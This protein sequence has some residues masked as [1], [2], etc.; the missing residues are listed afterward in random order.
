MLRLGLTLSIV[1]GLLAIGSAC[2]SSQSNKTPRQPIAERSVAEVIADPSHSRSVHYILRDGVTG[3]EGEFV[4][5]Q[6]KGWRR[7]DARFAEAA[8]GYFAIE[9]DPETAAQVGFDSVYCHWIRRP[10]D[11]YLSCTTDTI[12]AA[13]IDSVNDV[14]DA[15]LEMEADSRVWVNRATQCYKYDSGVL[16]GLICIDD[17]LQIPLYI[18]CDSS[19]CFS[20]EATAVDDDVMGD[21]AF[22]PTG[23]TYNDV[24]GVWHGEGVVSISELDL[25]R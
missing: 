15:S 2:G 8:S 14:L 6:T 24:A 7:L 20:I 13:R 25:P 4:W 10:G 18:D 22:P 19:P 16:G 1:T 3:R 9:A 17:Q 5:R 21:I 12:N 11:A 23:L